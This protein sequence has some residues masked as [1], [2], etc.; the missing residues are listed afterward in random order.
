MWISPGDFL[1]GLVV[2]GALFFAWRVWVRMQRR[3]VLRALAERMGMHFCP[4]DRFRLG[5]RMS[6]YL[7]CPGAADVRVYDVIYGMGEDRHRY[8]FA[9]EFTRGVVLTK[10]RNRRI[11]GM[12]E[13]KSFARGGELLVRLSPVDRP[14]IE[15]YQWAAQTP[16]PAGF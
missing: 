9:A 4:T 14:L 6:P 12:I 8:I 2:A 5:P 16:S 10:R 13:P 1:V 15:Q 11:V 3:R 7:D